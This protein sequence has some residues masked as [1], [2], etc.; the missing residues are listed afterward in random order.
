MEP[1]NRFPQMMQEYLIAKVRAA[2]VE[3]DA[4]KRQIRTKAHALA[5]QEELREKVRRIFGPFPKRTPLNARTTGVLERPGYRMEKIIFESRPQ[6]PVTANLYI[7]DTSGLPAPCVLAACGHSYNGKAEEKYQSFC[8]GLVKKGYVVLIY[9]PIG[10]GERLQYPDGRGGSRY[11]VGVGEHI[12]AANQQLL[13]GEFFGTWRVW[14]GIRALDYLLSRPEVDRTHIGVTGNSGGGTLTTLLV[15][16]DDRFTMAAPGCYVTT[17]RRNAENELPADSEQIPPGLLAL[18]MDIDD[19]LALHAPKPLILLTQEKDYFDQRGSVEVFQRLQRLYRLLGKPENLAMITGPEGHGYGKP[20]REAMYGFFNRA[21]GREEDSQE[22]PL[23][24]EPDELLYATETGQ[25]ADLSVRTVFSFTRQTAAALAS[26][27]KP[28]EGDELRRELARLLALPKRSGAPEFRILRPW[29]KRGYPRSH[30][31]TYAVE[32]EP[33]AWAILTML[34][35]E[36]FA[37]RPPR[38]TDTTLYVSHKSA[39]AELRDNVFTRELVAHSERFFALDVRGV[40]DSQPNTCGENMVDHPY[41]SDYF[42]SSYGILFSEPYVGRRTHDVLAVLDLLADY[43]YERVHLAALGFGTLP[44]LFAA[45]LDDRVHQ[46]TLK[47]A[48]S[49][50]QEVAEDEDFAWPLSSLLPNVLKTLDL[51]DCYRA[52]QD[53][54]LRLIE[55]LDACR[56][57]ISAET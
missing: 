9:D 41:G 40:G 1:L 29:G 4:R 46:V 6:F 12:H 53:K 23:Q 45:V 32:T 42:Y 25:V 2:E 44:A 16:N 8:Q 22:P 35:D 7:P 15:A 17:F 51:P 36:P 27:R 19:L 30:A 47:N 52:L 33:H 34:S 11:G 50:Y 38:G 39:D 13:I 37:S 3:A 31:A 57:P 49:S 54:H 24:I 55:P 43:G 5:Y 48:L 56:R 18:G 28:L 20:L 14:D 10:Q 26:E 21:C